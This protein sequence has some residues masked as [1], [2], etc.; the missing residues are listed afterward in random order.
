MSDTLRSLFSGSTG[1]GATGD[2]DATTDSASSQE[3]RPDVS[4]GADIRVLGSG[5]GGANA[6]SRMIEAKINGVDF[7][8]VNTDVQALYHNPAPKKVTIGRGTT[9]G[10]GAG[11]NPDVGKKQRK[12]VVRKLNLQ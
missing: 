5:G 1:S 6:V 8:A 3:V 9:K 12:K 4:P 10:L 2:D 11:A 7:V